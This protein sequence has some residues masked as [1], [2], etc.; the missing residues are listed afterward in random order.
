MLRNASTL[1]CLLN[2]GYRAQIDGLESLNLQVT[3][4]SGPVPKEVSALERD[5]LSLFRPF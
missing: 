1:S 2:F 3:A 4:L 5:Q